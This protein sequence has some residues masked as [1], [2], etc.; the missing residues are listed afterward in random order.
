MHNFDSHYYHTL[1]R[2]KSVGKSDFYAKRVRNGLANQGHLS[3]D[4]VQSG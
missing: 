3:S 4:N 1:E 2:L